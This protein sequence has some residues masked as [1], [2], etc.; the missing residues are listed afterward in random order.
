MLKNIGVPPWESSNHNHPT[1][2]FHFGRRELLPELRLLQLQRRAALLGLAQLQRAE[3]LVSLQ[4]LPWG[5]VWEI[6]WEAIF[7]REKEW[8]PFFWAWQNMK[9]IEETPITNRSI[10]SHHAAAA[11]YHH[12]S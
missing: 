11:I 9:N 12:W 3:A 6:L 7:F 8:F 4:I 1:W 5:K 10:S 2:Q